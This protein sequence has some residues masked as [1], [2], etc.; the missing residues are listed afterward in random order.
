M[1]NTKIRMNAYEKAISLIA[2]DKTIIDVDV[3]AGTGIL[4]KFSA[5]TGQIMFLQSKALI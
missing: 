2:K 4:S 1:M 5:K 3:D